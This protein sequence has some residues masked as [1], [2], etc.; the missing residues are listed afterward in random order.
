MDNSSSDSSGFGPGAVVPFGDSFSSLIERYEQ[1][2]VDRSKARNATNFVWTAESVVSLIQ[3]YKSYPC[4]WNMRAACYKSAVRKTAA[5]DEISDYFQLPV[6]DLKRKMNNLLSSYRRERVKADSK[7]KGGVPYESGLYF[8]KHFDFMTK[9]YQPKAFK[10]T[11]SSSLD[12]EAD[13]YVDADQ[14]AKVRY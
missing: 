11:I 4:L 10:K 9:V 5:W 2:E 8:Y 13:Y 3:T 14:I 12:L 6:N 1:S 7:H